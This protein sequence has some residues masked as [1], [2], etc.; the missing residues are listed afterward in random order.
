[1]THRHI[2]A[3][4]AT[5][6]ALVA[7]T[8]LLGACSEPTPTPTTAPT[9]SPAMTASPSPTR[10]IEPTVTPAEAAILEAYDGF[11][12]A[13]VAA[14]ADPTKDP[15]PELARYAVDKALADTA[16]SLFTFRDSGIAFTGEPTLDPVVTDVIEGEAGTA[17]ITDCVDS[18]AWLPIYTATGESAAAPGQATSVVAISTAYFYDGHWT[19]RTSDID[20]DTTC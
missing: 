14:F 8:A 17:T 12:D 15:G 6:T 2:T 9:S 1:M 18:S 13:K 16:T 4:A 10:T 3:G 5:A 11:W 7:I 20:R 19:I